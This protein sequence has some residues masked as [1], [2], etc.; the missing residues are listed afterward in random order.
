MNDSDLELDSLY[1]TLMLDKRS[2]EA[3]FPLFQGYGGPP[4]Y[5]NYWGSYNHV[6]SQWNPRGLTDE[7]WVNTEGKKYRTTGPA[8]ISRLYDIVAWYKD[9]QLHND[10]GWAYR[11]KNNYVWF[12]EGK[13]H[14]L[15]G[16]AVIEMGGPKQY[17]IDGVKYTPKQYKWEIRRRKRKGLL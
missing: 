6:P 14:N 12:K 16:P 5:W 17:W 4:R 9:D 8:Y 2:E 15:N 13:L 11:H 3:R 1:E 7:V 10:N